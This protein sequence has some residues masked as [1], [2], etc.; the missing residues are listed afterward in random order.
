MRP[1][2]PP[3]TAVPAGL[4]SAKGE[5]NSINA[6]N[7]GRNARLTNAIDDN[8]AGGTGRRVVRDNAID[9]SFNGGLPRKNPIVL[10]SA[11][12]FD[13]DP[14]PARRK[15]MKKT[16]SRPRNL[17]SEA[18]DDDDDDQPRVATRRKRAP[19]PDFAPPPP[20]TKAPSKAKGKA[21]PRA[22]HT[23]SSDSDDTS[24]ANTTR[25]PSVFASPSRGGSRPAYS[26]T[27]LWN[28]PARRGRTAPAKRTEPDMQSPVPVAAK[29]SRHL[30]YISD[31]DEEPRSIIKTPIRPPPAAPIFSPAIDPMFTL[32]ITV[33]GSHHLAVRVYP[34]LDLAG[35]L[36]RA[37]AHAPKELV[38]LRGMA[39]IK[40]VAGCPVTGWR[41]PWDEAMW[42]A[43][44]AASKMCAVAPEWRAEVV[45]VGV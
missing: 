43:V 27:A 20:R 21:V 31:D 40:G 30:T 8:T 44:V 23:F 3:V 18:D 10:S 11:S 14:I 35:L 34:G 7:V 45:F 26:S 42:R 28:S 37:F 4:I 19:I 17:E 5:I 39:R 15:L 16:A 1:P 36:S 32:S 12:E 41:K 24:Q 38:A 2:R 29:K 9:G 33:F 22:L 13:E 25:S 6:G